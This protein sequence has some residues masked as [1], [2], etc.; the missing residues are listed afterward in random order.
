MRGHEPKERSFQAAWEKSPWIVGGERLEF[1][2]FGKQVKI[3]LKLDAKD[4]ELLFKLMSKRLDKQ[5]RI[6]K[7]RQAETND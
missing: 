7:K 4:A 3:G 2:Y 6:N 5:I 1:D